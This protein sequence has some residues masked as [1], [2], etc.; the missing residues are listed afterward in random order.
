[1]DPVPLC[2]AWQLLA[3][4]DVIVN[5][6]SPDSLCGKT[7]LQVHFWLVAK[8]SRLQ[9]CLEL[10]QFTQDLLKWGLVR[11]KLSFPYGVARE[12]NYNILLE[13]M[14]Y[15]S[16]Y[17]TAK[18][19][20]MLG[21]SRLQLVT[22]E[23]EDCWFPKA[24]PTQSLPCLF[25][26]Y[27]IASVYPTPTKCVYVFDHHLSTFLRFLPCSIASWMWL[28]FSCTLRFLLS[29]CVHGI[30]DHALKLILTPKF[31]PL[32]GA[33]SWP[34]EKGIMYISMDHLLKEPQTK[35]FLHSSY[36]D[37]LL[38]DRVT[39]YQF[40]LPRFS[41]PLNLGMRFFVRGEGC[42]IQGFKFL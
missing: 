10:C 16:R 22:S 18:K 8:L 1:M 27:S 20:V 12:P 17:A 39:L 3:C 24:Q 41:S 31:P 30:P 26:L 35:R 38:P 25:Q 36:L 7:Q 4:R 28:W 42:N 29:N 15:Y 2:L 19:G 40:L 34:C 32:E 33:S 14:V 6:P 23:P 21:F 13:W 37:L 5:K 11:W 9:S